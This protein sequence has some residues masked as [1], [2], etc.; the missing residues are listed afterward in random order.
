MR[1]GGACLRCAECRISNRSSYLPIAQSRN[2]DPLWNATAMLPHLRKLC[3]RIPKP[4]NQLFCSRLK[5]CFDYAKISIDS[6]QLLIARRHARQALSKPSTSNQGSKG[7]SPW[8]WV[9]GVRPLPAAAR[10][11]H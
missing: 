8:P 11:G 6:C 2:S 5:A 7:R 3:L 10:V 1:H 4:V 9:Q